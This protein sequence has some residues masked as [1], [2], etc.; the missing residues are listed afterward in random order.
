MKKK[1]RVLGLFS[2]FEEAFAAIAD[3]RQYKVP[4]VSVDDVR[5][6]SPIE[7]PEI[8]EVLGDRPAHVPKFTL[9]GAIFGITFGFLFLASAQ[10]NFLVQPQGGK[11]VV[12]LPSNIVLTYEMLILFGVLFTVISFLLLSGLLFGKKEKLY[13]EKIAVDQIGIIM[14]LDE[15]T[16]EP[17]KALFRQHKVLEIREEVI[18]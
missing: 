1:Y 15:D 7:H 16:F 12:P 10:A 4:G 9:A 6:M 14:E 18:K 5:L 11:P 2:D 13:S 8:E 17:L 3:I